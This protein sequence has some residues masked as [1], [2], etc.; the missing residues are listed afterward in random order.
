V[1]KRVARWDGGADGEVGRV[2][3]TGRDGVAR[4]DRDVAKQGGGGGGG[5]PTRWGGVPDGDLWGPDGMGG[6]PNGKDIGN[7]RGGCPNKGEG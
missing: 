6:C 5:C 1:A 2:C 4:W 3:K 7:G